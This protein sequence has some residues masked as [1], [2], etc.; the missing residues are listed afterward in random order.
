MQEYTCNSQTGCSTPRAA[1]A[2]CKVYHPDRPLKTTGPHSWIGHTLHSSLYY[3]QVLLDF[4]CW[5]LPEQQSILT[6]LQWGVGGE[7]VI[8]R[9]N[10]ALTSDLGYTLLVLPSTDFLCYL[11]I[12]LV[13]IKAGWTSTVVTRLQ[14]FAPLQTEEGL[15]KSFYVCPIFIWHHFTRN[16][17]LQNLWGCPS[18]SVTLLN[19][20]TY[21]PWAMH[22]LKV[23]RRD[24]AARSEH[25]KKGQL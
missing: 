23:H 9:E 7:L 17:R 12:N 6:L 3:T 25:Q 21:L 15:V 22:S 14:E 2:G 24:D 13:S 10:Q 19:G 8:L 11:S 5:G 18:L 1:S 20:M 4:V 16:V